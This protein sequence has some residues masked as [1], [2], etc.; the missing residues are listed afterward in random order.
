MAVSTIGGNTL[1]VGVCSV[2]FDPGATAAA[3]TGEHTVTV[4][5]VRLGDYVCVT[6]PTGLNAGLGIVNASVTAADTVS[7]RFVN[8]TAGSLNP[9][10]ATY[11]VLI[12]RPESGTFNGFAP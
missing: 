2:T 12:I 3:T 10:S 11:Q 8:A 6:A 9:T 5:G 7:G 4:P 1:A